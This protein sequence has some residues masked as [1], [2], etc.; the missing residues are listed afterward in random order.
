MAAMASSLG[1]LNSPVYTA[2]TAPTVGAVSPVGPLQGRGRV[3]DMSGVEREAVD[4]GMSG[5]QC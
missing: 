2:P 5:V 1:V 3:G 4:A